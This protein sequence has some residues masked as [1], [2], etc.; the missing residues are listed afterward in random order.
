MAAGAVLAGNVGAF[1]R[2]E[3]T[4][5]G[6]PVN[7]AARLCELAKSDP[8]RVLSSAETVQASAPDESQH[9]T[10]G[11]HTVLRGLDR[12]TQLA[13]PNDCP[14]APVTHMWSSRCR[15]RSAHPDFRPT[16]F[17]DRTGSSRGSPLRSC[18]RYLCRMR[19][20]Q[21]HVGQP[22]P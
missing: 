15:R 12:L 4:V 13:S 2:F 18:A 22:N 6:E 8:H 1:E 16:W 3:Y 9:W 19:V 14:P 17:G 21:G 20:Q 5:I 11:G 7:I 10:L